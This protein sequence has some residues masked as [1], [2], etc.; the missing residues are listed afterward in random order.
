MACRITMIRQPTSSRG[1][2]QRLLALAW[3]LLATGRAP[4]VEIFPEPKPVVPA[5]PAPAPAAPLDLPPH[6]VADFTRRVQP[7]VLNRCASG[8][9][10]GSPTGPEPQFTR[11]DPRGGIDHRTTQANLR[12]FLVALG[13]EPD[14]AKLAALLAAGHPAKPANQRLVAAPLSPQERISLE[15][16]LVGVRQSGRGPIVDYAVQPATAIVPAA[17]APPPA[18]NRFKALLDTA[19]N[20][21]EFPPP[22]EPKG[23]IFPKDAP[24]AE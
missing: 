12:A 17:P 6:V 20:P 22:E 11:S 21:P 16:W 2:G 8:A 14:A 7:L 19:A 4:A 1:T 24:P 18:P 9:C 15:R 5:T 23:V 13:P 10:H 3:L